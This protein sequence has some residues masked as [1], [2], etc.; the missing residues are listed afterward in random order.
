MGTPF[1]FEEPQRYIK[2]L[3]P[4]AFAFNVVTWN[5]GYAGPA[6]S[7]T[8]FN[9]IRIFAGS[10]TGAFIH[11]LKVNQCKVVERPAYF[12]KYLISIPLNSF[13]FSVKYIS[14]T[15]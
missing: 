12:F 3:R 1:I 2:K 10:L 14:N 4:L 8:F 13:P 5:C 11:L 7:K 6:A 9:H 15:W